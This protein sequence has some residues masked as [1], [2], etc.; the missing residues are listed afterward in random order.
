YSGKKNQQHPNKLRRLPFPTISL[1]LFFR[2]CAPCHHSGEAGPFPLISY[3][4]VK[5]HARQIADVR[6]A[7][8]CRRGCLLKTA[9]RLKTT[10]IFF[11]S[12]SHSFKTGL[13]MEHPKVTALNSLQRPLSLRD[14]NLAHLI[15]Y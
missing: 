10:R 13:R 8:S 2:S 1:P 4:D 14:G 12:K 6:S 9:W 7:K 11:L 3:G 5:S 15:S